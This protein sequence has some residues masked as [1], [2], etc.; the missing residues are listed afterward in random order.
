MSLCAYKYRIYP[1]CEQVSYLSQVFGSVRFVW[2]QLVKNFNS[3]DKN[4]PNRPMSEKILKD[5]PQYPWLNESI[6]YALQQKRMD[7][8]ETKKQYFNKKRKVQ[9]GRMSFKKRGG[10]DSFR[11]PG[12]ALGFNSA[13]DFEAST[14]KIPKMTPLKLIVDRKFSGEVKSAT[15]SKNP[16]GQYFASIL[17]EEEIELMQNTGRSIGIDLGLTSLITL[18]DGTKVDNPRWFR[19]SQAKLARA[20]KWLAKKV[21]G[22]KRRE[23]QRIKVAKIYQKITNQRDWFLHN[24]STWLVHNY[25]SICTENLRVK[26]MIKNHKIAKSIQDASWAKLIA[27]INYKSTWYGKSFV[28]VDTWFASSKICSCCGFKM[29][30]MNLS[31][32]SWTCPSCG[33]LH[34]RD[35]NAAIN[36]ENQGLIDLYEFKSDELA[37]YKRREELSP[38][39]ELHPLMASSMKRLACL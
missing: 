35:I 2:N 32:R 13:I 1:T 39:T 29:S 37:D 3:Y 12:Q 25:D 19:E 26:N 18:S 34:D 10:R 21:K 15:I 8:E 30:E 22:S 11:I 27:M 7:F 5:D 14:L 23:K 38:K 36:I 6:S 9:L 16:S 24:L 28:K 4:G 17:V 31:V 20:Q 33:V